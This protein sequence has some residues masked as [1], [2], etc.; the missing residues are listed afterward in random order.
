MKK[1]TTNKMMQFLDWSYELA[2]KGTS[3]LE[4]AENLATD[5]LKKT[6]TKEDAA[7]SLIKWQIAKCATSGFITGI[8]GL[9]TLP[10]TLPVNMT[11]VLFI[12]LRMIASLAYIGGYDLNDDRVKTFVYICL[13]GHSA[14]N[15]LKKAGIKA[16]KGLTMNLIKK[17]PEKIIVQINRKI[18]FRLIEKFGEKGVLNLSKAI[19]LAGGVIGALFDSFSTRITA[20][21]AYKRFIEE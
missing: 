20:K 13:C 14:T 9:I 15:I 18:G 4:S 1:L 3:G 17:I 6:E 21:A 7:N 10:I 8:G 5:Y 2:L 19:P 11:S 12:Q 16:G